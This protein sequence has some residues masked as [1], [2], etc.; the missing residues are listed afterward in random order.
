[1]NNGEMY[2][3]IR[4][5]SW[6]KKGRARLCTAHTERFGALCAQL[7]LDLA[8]HMESVARLLKWAIQ[9]SSSAANINDIAKELR[10][11]RNRIEATVREFRIRTLVYIAPRDEWFDDTDESLR[12]R[13]QELREA[14]VD[15]SL[16]TLETL[17]ANLNEKIQA[18]KKKG[19]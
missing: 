7:H 6:F 1:M 19:A 11:C 17:I 5:Q 14:A 2:R 9:A 12:T 4:G 15:G 16:R 10:A 18:L 13:Y 3:L 8:E